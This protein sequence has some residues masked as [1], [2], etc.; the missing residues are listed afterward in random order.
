MGSIKCASSMRFCLICPGGRGFRDYP[1][2]DRAEEAFFTF[3][4]CSCKKICSCRIVV[5]HYVDNQHQI[6]GSVL[7]GGIEIAESTSH[8]SSS[9]VT[10][11]VTDVRCD[12]NLMQ[13]AIK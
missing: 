2:Q 13:T 3:G 7:T 10:K 8:S 6:T 12:I 11:N 5:I 9:E 1:R 4:S